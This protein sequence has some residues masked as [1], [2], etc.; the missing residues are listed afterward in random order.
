MSQS[1]PIPPAGFAE[2]PIEEQINY[3]EALLDLVA[4]RPDHVKIPKWHW[5]IL[6]ERLE[7]FRAEVEQGMTWEEFEKE[8]EQELTQS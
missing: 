3:I 2:L 8:L 4:S 1:L 5:E 6:T 7:G